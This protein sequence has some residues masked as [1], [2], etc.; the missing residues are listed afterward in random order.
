MFQF[1]LFRLPLHRTLLSKVYGASVQSLVIIK[2]LKIALDEM[3][4]S[5]MNLLFTNDAFDH[6]KAIGKQIPHCG[7]D[8]HPFNLVF[9]V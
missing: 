7:M 1:K 8:L 2:E 4:W 5:G 3:D 9:I 6:A